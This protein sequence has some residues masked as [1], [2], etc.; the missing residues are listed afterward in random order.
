MTSSTSPDS[1]FIRPE[2][3]I[4]FR[5]IKEH[6]D[7]DTPRLIFADW[8]QEHGDAATAARGEF[9]RLQVLRHRLSQDDPNYHVLKRREG[10]LFTQ[11]RWTW[12]GPLADQARRWDFEGGMIQ[13]TAQAE[14]MLVPGVAAWARTE[15]GWWIDALILIDVTSA[16]INHLTDSPLLDHLNVLYLNGN[17]LQHG[18][19]RLFRSHRLAFITRLGLALNRLTAIHIAC[20]VQS[21]SLPRLVYLD[22]Q[23][24]QLNDFAIRIL[25]GAPSLQK[26]ATLRL[27]HNRFTAEGIALLREAFGDRVHL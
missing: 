20:L 8:L 1:S 26:L 4:F 22:L 19:S 2:V 11:Y 3:R 12:L 17:D 14:K 5:D 18:L 23:V 10:E 24:N 21:L 7:D 9:L 16:H 27:E 25:A 6:P 15:A 13:I